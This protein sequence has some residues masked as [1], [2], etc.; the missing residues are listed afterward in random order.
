MRASW[1]ERYSRRDV[2]RN[3]LA[4]YMAV[5]AVHSGRL[6]LA[7]EWSEIADLVEKLGAIDPETRGSRDSQVGAPY[8][9]LG[10]A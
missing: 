5:R 1:D 8:A 7:A 9:P 10:A 6:D 2:M 3:L 4:M